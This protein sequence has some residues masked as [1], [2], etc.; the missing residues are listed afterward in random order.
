[1]LGSSVGVRVAAG[2]VSVAVSVGSITGVEVAGSGVEV[3]GMGVA[4]GFTAVGGMLVHV[5]GGGGKVGEIMGAGVT[6]GGTTSTLGTNRCCPT[7]MVVVLRQ[8]RAIKT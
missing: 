7:R 8:L 1:M 3:A 5:A 6:L 2:W 4:E